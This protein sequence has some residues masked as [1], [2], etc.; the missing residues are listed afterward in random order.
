MYVVATAGHVDH[1]KSTLLRALT[2]M[3]PDRWAEE[4]RRGMTLDLGFVWTS[5]ADGAELAFVDVPGHER[6]V[7]TMLAGV[8]SVPAALV[9]VAADG[10]WQAQTSEHVEILDAFGVEHAVLAVTRA[11]LADPG[12]ALE[13]AGQRLARTSMGRHGPVEAVAVSAVTGVGLD[14]LRGALDRMAH[15]LPEPSRR[16]RV[17]FFVDR[18]FT[19]KGSGTVVTGTLGSGRFAAGDQ[20]E[21]H[22]GG[23]RTRVRGV[24]TLDR[25]VEEVEAVARVALN[26]RGVAVD[27]VGRGSVLLT[28][29]AWAQTGLFDVRLDA[30]DPA[31]LPGDLVLHLGAAAIPVRIRPLGEDTG[32]VRAAYPLPLQPGDRAVL[33]DPSRRLVTGLLVLDVDP[34]AFDRRGA[35]RQRADDL[36]EA[37]GRPDVAAEVARRGAVTRARLAALGVLPLEAALPP[38]VLELAEYAVDPDS[39][40]RWGEQ[41]RVAVDAHQRSAPL[42]NGISAEAARQALHLPDARLLEAL[43]RDQGGR[44]TSA[45]GRISRPGAGPVFSA[46]VQQQLDA[47]LAR[48][49]ADPFDAPEAQ[50]LAGRG[51]DGKVLGAAARKGLVL[52]LKGDILV[53]P[54]APER[55]RDLLATLEQPFTMSAARQALGTTRRISMPLLEH[56]DAIGLTDRLDANLRRVRAE[57]P[58]D[59]SH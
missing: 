27:E 2:G 44:L 57:P 18:A 56:L 4:R 32:R 10:G 1:G 9:V 47:V 59:R 30:L 20:L 35:A 11:D 31:D 25:P 54:S 42:A 51:L 46:A 22:P 38:S 8:G 34:P 48:L 58:P 36:S 49:E 21:I 28:P 52:R 17:R 39:W 41:L 29:D 5:L 23:A 43:V 15:R 45:H 24:Q 14:R 13:Y 12:P 33:R 26:L 16:G 7:S 50:E 55:A 6:F 19:V 3:E 37:T 40:Q 53:H